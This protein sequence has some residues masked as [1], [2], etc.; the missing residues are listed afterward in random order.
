MVAVRSSRASFVPA[1]NQLNPARYLPFEPLNENGV[2]FIFALAA[3]RLG[4]EVD[5]VQ[6]DYPDCIARWQGR[7]V[8]IEFEFRSKNFEIHGHDP[9]KCDLIVCWQHN[10][11]GAPNGL[12]V[13]EL[14][15]LFGRAR[16]VFLVAYRD[17]FW[18]D[19]P[20]DRKA[21][22][23]WS[24]P[25]TSGPDDVLLIYRPP[26]PG[27]RKPGAVTDV[28]RVATAPERMKQPG[29]RT[30]PDWMA[31]IQRVAR[32]RAPIPF[33]RLRQIDA[34]GGIESRPRRTE[35]WRALHRVIVEEGQPTHSLSRYAPL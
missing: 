28:F 5:Q 10:W 31:S 32:L 2:V 30:E 26:D 19:L 33:D 29:W 8:R 6:R 27:D 15:K 14:R 13:L 20:R 4:F 9:R 11:A 23:L 16:D 12:Q 22:D 18:R 17:E 21:T 25:S 34:H 24:V 7:K 3:K 35:Q 1:V